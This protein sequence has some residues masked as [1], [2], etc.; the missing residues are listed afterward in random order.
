MDSGVFVNLQIPAES[1]KVRRGR[2]VHIYAGVQWGKCFIYAGV[3]IKQ[4]TVQATVHVLLPDGAFSC[5]P[6]G[7]LHALC[8][9]DIIPVE[10]GVG[11]L[12]LRLWVLPHLCPGAGHNVR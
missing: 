6:I 12:V 4:S 3:Q 5:G 7:A 1:W 9:P 11:D 10:S 8:S 2:S